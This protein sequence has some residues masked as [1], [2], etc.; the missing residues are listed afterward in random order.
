MYSRWFCLLYK[1]LNMTEQIIFKSKCHWTFESDEIDEEKN[2][3]IA[4]T[5][6]RVVFY[7]KENIKIS[8]PLVNLKDIHTEKVTNEFKNKGYS[9]WF[10]ILIYILLL[11]SKFIYLIDNAMRIKFYLNGIEQSIEVYHQNNNNW[12]CI[13]DYLNTCVINNRKGSTW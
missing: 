5:N 7:D 11:Y 8:I 3:L 2:N 10:Y 1:Y 12:N 6:L 9:F 13:L 4:V